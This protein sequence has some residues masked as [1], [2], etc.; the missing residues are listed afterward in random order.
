[1]YVAWLPTLLSQHVKR[2]LVKARLHL[3]VG[4]TSLPLL[5]L[6][7]RKKK[8]HSALNNLL[9][10]LNANSMFFNSFFLLLTQERV[11]HILSP[12]LMK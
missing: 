7:S 11:L 4:Y 6:S 2:P 12:T 3:P 10:T 1:M 8:S 9:D 5:T